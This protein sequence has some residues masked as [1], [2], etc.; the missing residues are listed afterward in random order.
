MARYYR[1]RRYG[2]RNNSVGDAAGLL[3]LLALAYTYTGVQKFTEQNSYG[4]AIIITISVI[5]F[6]LIIGLVIYR[7][8]RAKHIYD[9]ITL[10]QVDNMDGLEFERYLADLLRK[11]GFMDVKLTER[12]DYGI[13]I[14][15]QKDGIKWGIQAK[16]Y[17]SPVKAAAVRQVYTALN[18]YGCSRAMVIAN[19]TY[20]RPARLLA[21]DNN[22]ALI[23]RQTLSEWI[24]EASRS[25]SKAVKQNRGAIL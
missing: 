2:K 18:R 3:A 17:N 14:I 25:D 10:A 7:A 6:G 19:N 21:Q 1:K 13:D 24:Y 8:I 22:I 12:F 11:K 5:I 23:D 16:R 15:A 4:L 20:T 9:A